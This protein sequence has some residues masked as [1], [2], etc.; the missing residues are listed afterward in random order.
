MKKIGAVSILVTM[1]IGMISWGANKVYSK[2]DEHE[3]KIA[4]LQEQKR[5][6][7]QHNKFQMQILKEIK[8]MQKETRADI[9]YLL[10]QRK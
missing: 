7:R 6:Q 4:V 8:E 9:K 10:K 3:V 2:V 5:T 1:F